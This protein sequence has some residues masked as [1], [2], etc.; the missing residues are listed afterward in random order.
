VISFM[1][2]LRTYM[3]D[4]IRI[5]LALSILHGVWS[6]ELILVSRAAGLV[7]SG[8]IANSPRYDVS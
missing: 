8:L 7:W 4:G 1:Q 2:S 6:D 3:L 5:R